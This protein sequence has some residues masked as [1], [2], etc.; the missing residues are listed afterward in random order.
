MDPKL[1]SHDV[2]GWAKDSQLCVQLRCNVTRHHVTDESDVA[3]DWNG[4]N[5]GD[6]MRGR[7][8][9]TANENMGDAT[10]RRVQPAPESDSE[11]WIEA[12]VNC[13]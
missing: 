5:G 3:N 6:G 2:G 4:R 7:N 9:M 13:Y 10:F 12:L 1:E 8:G 11:P